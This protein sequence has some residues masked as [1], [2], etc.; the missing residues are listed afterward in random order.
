[1]PERSR[2]VPEVTHY[3]NGR[4]KYRGAHLDGEMHGPWEFFR[5]DGT[6]MRTGSFER[7]RQVGVWRT[8]GRNRRVVKETDFG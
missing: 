7:G 1:M 3:A 6:L 5:T 4:V 2:T 8:F